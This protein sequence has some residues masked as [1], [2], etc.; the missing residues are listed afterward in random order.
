[1]SD[2]VKRLQEQRANAFEDAKR[3]LDAAA[4]ENRELSAEEQVTYDRINADIDGMAQRATALLDAEQRNKDAAEAFEKLLGSSAPE[5]RATKSA[6]DEFR[7]FARGEGGRSFEV[8]PEARDLTKGTATAGGNTVPTSFYDQLWEHMIEVSGVLNASPTILRTASGESLE[9]P[10][11]T[12]HSSGA[13]I[14]EAASIT[15]SDPAFAKRTLG[16]YKY[17]VSLQA[18][19][20]LLTDTGVDLQS[21][22]SRQ[23]GRAVGNAL[24]VDLV[25]GN[26][27]AK[28]SGIVQTASTGVTG[29][30]AVAGVFTADNLIDL[31]FSVIAPYRNSRSCGWLMRDASLGAVRK[32]K[33]SNGQYLWQPSLVAGA[34]DLL[35]G[36]PVHT[37]PNVAA[38]A[39]D[40][41]SVIFGD[42]SAYVVRLAGG[43]RF[44]RSDDFAFQNDLVTFRCIVRGDGI[45]ADQT[46]AV[47]VF[48]GGAAV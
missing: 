15:E 40:A 27:T 31:F 48:V 2:Y 14:A 24:G 7:A 20:E 26:A 36:K 43:I 28:P 39:A 19:S 3:L 23:A 21:Y 30:S 17:A 38:V 22:L 18:A 37:D 9:I 33:D 25:T 46:G 35:L 16:A 32:L 42:M 8:M 34:P 12:A 45:L 13:L 10:V 47:K 1:M 4:A 11:T 5:A 44:E 41:K 6:T 29:S